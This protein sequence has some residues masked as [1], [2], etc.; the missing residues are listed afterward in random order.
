MP[1]IPSL[2]VPF[3]DG[4]RIKMKVSKQTFRE[5]AIIMRQNGYRYTGSGIFRHENERRPY[6]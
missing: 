4:Y 3:Q 1:E 5:I 6:P 2:L